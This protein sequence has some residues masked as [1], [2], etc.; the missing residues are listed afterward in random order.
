MIY[1]RVC[2]T[3]TNQGLWYHFNGDFSGL[4][5]SKFDFCENSQLEMEFDPEIIGWLS[6]AQSLDELYKWFSPADIKE[7]QKHN[8]L[9][10]EYE[11]E[12]CK[13]YDRFQHYVIKQ[14]T[15]KLIRKY[16]I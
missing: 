9:I 16:E 12:D 13:F 5:H 15:A 6:V 14:E 7:L 3:D 11:S 10:H 4:I 8:W 1:Y 2:N